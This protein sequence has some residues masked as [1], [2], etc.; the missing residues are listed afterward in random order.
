[1]ARTLNSPVSDQIGEFAYLYEISYSGGTVFYTNA[2]TDITADDA[3]GVSRVWTAVGGS[4]IHDNAPDTTDVRGQSVKLQL[5]GVD[6]SVI[7]LIQNNNFRGRLLRIYLI[8][9]DPVTGTQF[10][11]DLIFQGR[12][13]GDYKI[14]ESRNH[15]STSGGGV[16][17]VSTRISADLSAINTKQSCRCNVASHQEMLRRS[18]VVAPDDKFFE[19]VP[20]IMGKSIVWGADADKSFSSGG[21][22]GGGG[23]GDDEPGDSRDWF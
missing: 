8:H 18:G 10:A 1:M 9:W 22:N 15:D 2:G 16:V 6:Q 17:T 20:T 13:N 4:L 11:P 3:D 14:S 5:F 12:Q 19:R 23:A 21:G 7:S